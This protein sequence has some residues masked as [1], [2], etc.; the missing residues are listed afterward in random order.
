MASIAGLAGVRAIEGDWLVDEGISVLGLFDVVVQ[1][2]QSWVP[3]AQICP[4]SGDLFCFALVYYF[5]NSLVL[6]YLSLTLLLYFL[7]VDS[8]LYRL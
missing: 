5:P 1:F 2:V 4:T 3:V 8:S 7:L 6:E